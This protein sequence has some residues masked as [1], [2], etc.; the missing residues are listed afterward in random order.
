MERSKAVELLRA[1]LDQHGLTDWG[2]RLNQ[3]INAPFLGL[4]SYKDK[5]IILNAHHVDQ[6][7]EVELINTIKHEVAHALTPGNG[8]NSVWAEKARE[9]GCDNVNPCAGF[10]LSPNIIDAIRSGAD[11]EVTI[12]ETVTRNF[13]YKVTRLQDKCETCGKVAVFDR[14]MTV[15]GKTETDHEVK[16][17]FLKCGHIKSVVL[18][19]A[20]PFHLMTWGGSLTCKHEWL[21]NTCLECGANRPFP[22]QVEGMKFGERALMMGKGVGIM[23]DM[24]LGKTVQAAG[25]VKHHPELGKFCLAVKSAVKFQFFKSFLNICGDEFLPQIINSSNDFLIPQLKVYIISYDMLVFKTKKLKS[26][27]TVKQG[28][29][30][31]KLIDA[32]VKCL[33]MD[34]CQQIKNPDSSR[35]Q[36][37]RKLAKHCKIIALSGTPWKNNGSEFFSVLNMIDPIRFNSYAAFCDRWVATYWDGNKYK[38]GGIKN[39]KHFQDFTKDFIIRRERATVLPE[40]PIINRQKLLVQMNEIEEKTYN[41]ETSDFVKC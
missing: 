32:G 30:V 24:G 36:E 28:F 33:I 17:T 20:T 5:C 12:D 40:L 11:I 29:D 1:E 37:M 21:R 26:G 6:H 9:I 13:N 38:T 15:P 10:G 35:T 3:N 16:I 14:E 25:I 31:Q 39:P 34:E 27:K 19:K 18:P 4:C 2:I 7:P 8:H 23:D 41:D 22:F